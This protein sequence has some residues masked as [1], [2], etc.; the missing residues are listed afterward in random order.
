MSQRDRSASTT[1]DFCEG[2]L[3]VTQ[4]AHIEG[5]PSTF[6]R[7]NE[8]LKA[9]DHLIGFE[10]GDARTGAS[11]LVTTLEDLSQAID[12]AEAIHQDAINHADALSQAQADA[13]VRSAEIIE[14]LEQTKTQLTEARL[15]AERHREE[16][17]NLLSR[18]FENAREGVVILDAEGLIQEVNPVFLTVAQSDEANL[19]GLPLHRTLGWTFPDYDKV[20]RSVMSGQAW[21]GRAIV[22]RNEEDRSYLISFSPVQGKGELSNVIVLFSDVTDIDRTQQCLKR[23]A[24]HD[25]LTGLPNRRYF[26]E[27]IEALIEECSQV[28]SSF[29][30]CFVDLDDFK[31]VND[32]HG[33]LAGDQLLVEVSRRIRNHSGPDAFVARFGG[34]EFAILIPRTDTDLTKTA[35]I[36]DQVLRSLREPIDVLGTDLRVSA[37]LGVTEYPTQCKNVDEL[38]QYAD[39]AMYSAKKAGRNQ[40]RAFASE[41]WEAVEQ[42]HRIQRE[43]NRALQENE[44]S[45]VYQPQI[46]LKSGQCI[47]CE[48]LARWRT[49]DGQQISPAEFVPVAEQTGLVAPLGEAVLRM[50][51]L[52]L[53]EWERIGCRPDRVAVNLSPRQLYERSFI[54]EVLEILESTE[55]QSDWLTLEITENAVME[56]IPH[57]MRIMD[58]LSEVGFHIALDDFGTG[59]SSLSYLKQF[60]VHSLKIDRSFIMDLPGDERARSIVESV[61][62]LG[63]GR[64]LTVVA[65]GIET[66][67]QYRVLRDMGC[68]MGQGYHIARPLQPMDFESYF[69]PQKLLCR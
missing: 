54:V 36:T 51:C 21:T 10:L 9:L 37:S 69:E 38:L 16:R 30:V 52:Q 64:D 31:H 50:V 17:V 15:I 68:D 13:L 62:H 34:D 46:D 66:Q 33:H 4:G 53:A 67:T 40:I 20:L 26:R 63:Q 11:R 7:V 14:E 6:D 39:V 32:S 2:S 48:A 23:Q 61:I 19:I 55:A 35:T 41:M 29:A 56:D 42:R 28:R 24:L 18:V 44:I 60:N 49:P 3:P 25:Q 27:R 1:G 43:L 58:E 12:E 22:P 59:Y 47:G 8:Q 57:A 65:E 5:R 45:V